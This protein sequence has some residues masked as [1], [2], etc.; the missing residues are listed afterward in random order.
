MPT[1]APAMQRFDHD[2]SWQAVVPASALAA[3]ATK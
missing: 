3:G 1:A 2:A